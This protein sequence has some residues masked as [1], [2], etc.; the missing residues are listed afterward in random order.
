MPSEE[1]YEYMSPMSMPPRENLYRLAKAAML[2]KINVMGG[3]FTEGPVELLK[4]S[5]GC[6][7]TSCA[8]M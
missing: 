1:T 4:K 5:I 7:C 2:R 6:V 3:F 8:P